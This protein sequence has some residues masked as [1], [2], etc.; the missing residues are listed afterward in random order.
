M[1]GRG[2]CVSGWGVAGW[3]RCQAWSRTPKRV[4]VAQKSGV[5]VPGTG[6]LRGRGRAE[7]GRGQAAVARAGWAASKGAG[8]V[9]V[10]LDTV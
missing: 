8:R 4:T 7:V 3:S 6:G 10:R 9:L 1:G 2:E 5:S